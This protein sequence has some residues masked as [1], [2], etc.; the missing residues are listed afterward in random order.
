VLFEELI[1]QWDELEFIEPDV[2][3]P[4][5]RGNFVLGLETMPIRFRAVS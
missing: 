3:L 5:R 1:A 2:V 4:H